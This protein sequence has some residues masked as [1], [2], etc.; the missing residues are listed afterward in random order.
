[1][2]DGEHMTWEYAFIALFG[3]TTGVL[4]W[5]SRTLW[6]AVQKLKDDLNKLE[7]NIGLNYVRY[8]RLQDVMKPVLEALHEIKETLKDKA[9]KK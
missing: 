6:D 9:D 1:M 8:D 7:V 3:I 5:I 4:G 2:C